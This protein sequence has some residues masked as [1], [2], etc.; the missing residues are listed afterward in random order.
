MSES[1]GNLLILHAEDDLRL[2]LAPEL[3]R[4]CAH[5][6]VVSEFGLLGIPDWSS[7]HHVR[8]ARLAVTAICPAC[9]LPTLLVSGPLRFEANRLEC[10]L[11]LEATPPPRVQFPLETLP[12]T[13]QSLTEDALACYQYGQYLGMALLCHQV[14]RASNQVLGG[15]QRLRMFNIVTESAELADMDEPTL[16]LCRHIL[17]DLS[18]SDVPMTPAL[19]AGQARA[20]LALTRDLLHQLFVRRAQMRRAMTRGTLT[21]DTS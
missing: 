18:K 2:L 14:V 15:Q 13:V 1:A 6:D 10:A 17:F 5:C 20:L 8:P 16:R 4:R 12:A 3:T 7:L 19:S 11:P 21:S 9:R